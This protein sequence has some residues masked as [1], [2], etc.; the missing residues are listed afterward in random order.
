LTA[1]EAN[2]HA[3]AFLKAIDVPAADLA[4]LQ[5]MSSEQ[6]LTAYRKV[7]RAPGTQ[8]VYGPVVDGKFLAKSPW[9]PEGP[10]CSASI[11]MLI[12]TTQTETTALIGADDPSVFS[13]DD[14]GLRRS[15]TAWIPANEVDRVITGFR[16][17][18]PDASPSD[19]FFAITS[20]RRVRQQAWAQAE[21]KAAQNAAPIWLY[22]LDWRTQVDNG[23]WQSPHSL[24]L[25]LMFDN[26]ARSE[27]MV[28]RSEEARSLA[29][30]MSG[31]WLAFA[32][33]GNPNNKTLPP[34]A[35]FHMPERATMVFNT[36][37]RAVND[38]RGDERQLLASL[39]LY[40]VNR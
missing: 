33:T 7:M 4:R 12:G 5:K 22:E 11:P 34:W 24:D 37:S 38:F 9:I 27:S 31:A 21:H 10:A 16:K 19:L 36:K 23:K 14:A 20:A 32:R 6:L 2:G 13:L 1:D 35:P 29:E 28:G 26:T 30:Q 17:L 15:L 40:R 39:P 18:A 8:A 3:L 25:A